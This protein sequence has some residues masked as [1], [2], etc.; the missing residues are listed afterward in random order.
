M[1]YE[2]TPILPEGFE[3][4]ANKAVA[5]QE[6]VEIR[7]EESSTPILDKWQLCLQDSLQVIGVRR[8]VDDKLAGVGM[9]VGNPRHAE[10]VDLT[11]HSKF[12]E[13]GIG[14]AILDSLVDYVKKEEIDYVG[15]TFDETKPWLKQ[16][17]E[18]HGFRAISFGMR[19]GDSVEDTQEHLEVKQNNREIIIDGI[20][21]GNHGIK[22]RV[23]ET[24]PNAEYFEHTGKLSRDVIYTQLDDGEL[25]PAGT[26]YRRSEAEFLHGTEIINNERVHIFN[27]SQEFP[28]IISQRDFLE[29]WNPAGAKICWRHLC[30]LADQSG[31]FPLMPNP[32][33]PGELAGNIGDA[34]AW[35]ETNIQG[36][37]AYSTILKK[38]YK[39]RDKA[40]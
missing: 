34:L 27:L 33:R 30:M 38:I 32:G 5:P 6:I 13:R 18:K 20:Y 8:T 31:D 21:N 23:D 28:D 15:L 1:T 40:K 9:I 11:V 39:H 4:T 35:I 14:G 22:Y 3:F 17:Y 7:E 10:L 36:K 16:F 29:Q 24:L 25:M 37:P 2:S 26:R 12:R 19:L